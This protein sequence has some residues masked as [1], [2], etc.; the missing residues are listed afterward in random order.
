MRFLFLIGLLLISTEISAQKVLNIR[1]FASSSSIE[2]NKGVS[3]P[4]ITAGYTLWLPKKSAPQGLIVIQEERRDSVFQN[5]IV[6]NALRADLGIIY[7]TTNNPLE[8]HFTEKTTKVLAEDILRVCNN[9]NIPKN[10]IFYY[11][12]ELAGTRALKL[13]IFCEQNKDYND[14]KPMAIALF[15]APIDIHR[16]YN[17]SKSSQ[18]F[19]SDKEDREFAVSI[20]EYIQANLDGTP[21]NSKAR[22]ASYSP[23][24]K[25]VRNGGNAAYFTSTYLRGYIPDDVNYANPILGGNSF[26]VFNFVEQVRRLGSS[27]AEVVITDIKPSS[28][29]RNAGFDEKEVIS[30]FVSLLQI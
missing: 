1:Y 20:K 10:R 14:I 7:M 24:S 29:Q 8:F 18:Q 26:D 30:W 5:A 17:Y 16:Y 6:K 12:S 13:A 27:R 28:R 4:S 3:I 15:D 11:G 25:Y 21:L 2:I 22:Y 19:H 23:Y 9:F